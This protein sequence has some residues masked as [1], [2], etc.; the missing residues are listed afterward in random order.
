MPA[1]GGGGHNVTRSAYDP[2]RIPHRKGIVE[3]RRHLAAAF[4][5]ALSLV[6]GLAACSKDSGPEPALQAFLDGWPQSK[7]DG[8]AVQ[9]ETGATLAAAT[10]VERIKA[11][12]GDLAPAAIKARRAGAPTVTGDDA[13]AN[14]DVEWSVASGVDW[15]YQTVVRMKRQDKTWRVIWT[16]ATVHPDL[17][18]GDR[19]ATRLVKAER[20]QILD[21]AGT[22]IVKARPVVVVGIE[23]RR[24]V[25]RASLIAAL[26]AA[27]KSAGVSVNLA[28]L[29]AR[30]AG[31]KP[32]AFVDVVTLRRE[33]YDTIR[34]RIRDLP[35]TVFRETNL[36]LGPTRAFARALLGTVG[37]VQKEQMDASPGTFVVGDQVGQSGLQEEY[38]AVLRGTSGVK[39]VVTGRKSADGTAEAE[40]ALFSAEPKPGEALRTTLDSQLQSAAEAALAGQPRRAAIVA[41]R[42]SDGAI[43]AAANGPDGGEINLAF[44]ASVPPGSTF[45][46][47]T[48]LGLLDAGAVGLNTLVDCPRTF[49]VAGRQFNNAGNFQLGTVPFHVDFA[50]SCNTAFASLAPK[51]GGD[52]LQKAAASVGIGT[53]WQLGTEAFTGSVPANA[54]P[55]ESAAATFG[56][57]QTQVSPLAL[58]SAAG[59]VARGSWT[60]PKLFA[61]PPAGAA[62]PTVGPSAGAITPDG[63]ALNATSAAAVRT[64]MREVVT[65]G[66][67]STLV[68]V[69]G[70]P[71]HAKT[72]TA[73][74]DNNPA[75]THAWTIGWQGDI[76]F[77]VF[78]E[79]G[80][81]S[82]ATAVPIVEKFLRGVR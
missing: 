32:D 13:S 61:S 82:S 58:A 44:T 45:K 16:P 56:Q 75:H 50:K 36:Q 47:V 34:S 30:I 28:D 77:A 48:A 51:L 68:D 70:S 24:V 37:D 81:S 11:L 26:D 29:P 74:F 23:P 5:V 57:G 60:Q 20:G 80:G 42:V 12:S 25:N 53:T 4:V 35:G 19:L 54:S 9:D 2:V 31:A 39:V 66:T 17:K 71:V 46:M 79:N 73:E 72:G 67:A 59:A 38:D 69:P 41:V 63:T 10:V 64:M 6:A 21:G 7:L 18:A 15:R 14:V 8:V 78:V 52:G 62:T 49:S 40:L 43:V 1:V 33:V 76:A 3:M 55:V 22:A 27:F 65:A